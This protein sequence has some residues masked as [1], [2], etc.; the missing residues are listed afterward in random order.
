MWIM[1]L[2]LVEKART[3]LTKTIPYNTSPIGFL[4]VAKKLGG[5]PQGASGNS[6]YGNEFT[7]AVF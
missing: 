1:V 4:L 6:S 7:V 2:V 5:P 3:G